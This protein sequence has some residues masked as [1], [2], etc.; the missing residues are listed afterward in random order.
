M[1][2]SA[3]SMTCGT[4][5]RAENFPN[6]D[7]YVACTTRGISAK[8]GACSQW[9][10]RRKRSS[11]AKP[12]VALL[13]SGWTFICLASDRLPSI[14]IVSNRS[15][16]LIAPNGV[17]EPGLM[18]KSRIISSALPKLNLL[19]SIACGN[20]FRSTRISAGT[21]ISQKRPPASFRNRFLVCA[22]GISRSSRELSSTVKTASCSTS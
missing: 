14:T 18:P 5:F 10:S 2:N 19:L 7:V 12:I 15:L 13:R 8:T 4:R 1:V 16:S 17:T 21:V 22:P 6:Q 9:A 20:F 11:G 3:H